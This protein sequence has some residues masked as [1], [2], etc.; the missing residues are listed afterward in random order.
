M[1]WLRTGTAAA[2]FLAAAGGAVAGTEGRLE[3][4]GQRVVFLGDSITD[5]FSYPL[6]VRQALEAAGRAPPVMVCAGIGGDTAAGMEKRLDRDVFVHQPTL[7]SLSAG[8]NDVL[9]KVS[10]AEY[11]ESVRN[12]AAQLKAR[13][14]PLL[15]LTTSVLGPKAGDADRRLDEFNAALRALAKGESYRLADV[16]ELMK[17]AREGGEDPLEEDHVHPNYAGHRV[18]ARAVLDALGYADVPVPARMSV[19]LMPGVVRAW[20]LCAAPPKAR[21]LDDAAAAVLK[22]DG[23]WITYALP[24]TEPLAN[25]WLDQERQRGVA[26]SLEKTAGKAQV[27]YGV[28]EVEAAGARRAFVNTGAHLRAAWLN[29]KSIYRATDEWKGWHPG[30]ERIPVELAAGKNTLV[31]ETGNAF[32]LSITDHNDW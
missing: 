11:G 17:R 30:R 14:V 16:N 23:A 18:M 15:V 22:P 3:L 24:E 9:R 6:L 8:V 21:P 5:G 1:A 28:A 32:F 25:W 13:D 10:P 12:I 19:G 27:H 7:V 4:R 31:I 2:L 26:V 29:G 20:R